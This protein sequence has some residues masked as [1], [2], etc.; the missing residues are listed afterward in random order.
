MPYRKAF[1]AVLVVHLFL[2][3]AMSAPNIVLVAIDGLND[4]AT[5][6]HGADEV[7]ADPEI[8]ARLTP[9]LDRLAELGATFTCFQATDTAAEAD[10][11]SLAP[12]AG[13]VFSLLRSA[14]YAI[15]V[16]GLSADDLETGIDEARPFDQDAAAPH[17]RER[18]PGIGESED[19][20][21]RLRWSRLIPTA[22]RRKDDLSVEAWERLTE[23]L[24]EQLA[25]AWAADKIAATEAGAPPQFVAVRF[26]GPTPPWETPGVFFD[27]FPLDKITPPPVEAD[28]LDDL[29]E[30][31]KEIGR[32]LPP[33][34]DADRC[35]AIQAYLA[36]VSYADYALG[37]VVDAV[38][39]I[40]ADDDPDNDWA[41]AFVSTRGFQLGQKGA[42][43]GGTAWEAATHTNL[44]LYAPAIT[45]PGQKIDTPVS[46][47]DV[48]PTLCA[49]AGAEPA[50]PTRG[51]NLLPLLAKRGGWPGAV[52]LTTVGADKAVSVRSFRYRLI[53]YA[54]GAE[55]LYDHD[56]DSEERYNL[57]D[58]SHA[59]L[60][61][62]FGMSQTQ[63]EAVR[64]WLGGKLQEAVARREKPGEFVPA[65]A[66]LPGDFNR[67]G[68]VD[69]ADSTVW[70]DMLGQEV[71]VGE[72]ADGDFDGRVGANDRNIWLAN[73]GRTAKDE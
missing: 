70:R 52:A 66:P 58:P 64:Q 54:D 36:C 73:Y 51:D 33:L 2:A 63:V 21:F 49:L 50:S 17:R 34:E 45:T 60:V 24:N 32:R 38:E 12:A 42:W 68:R 14:G 41:L 53:R 29:P 20:A 59:V 26:P 10:P 11:L 39:A 13:D 1:L 47:A 23:S 61:D 56:H 9:N 8:R 28:G 31:A 67:D 5:P 4:F 7:L 3:A 22:G 30:T 44:M 62:R 27:R 65:K 15:A 16:T 19:G 57:L 18:G 35:A 55:E 37:K 6:L 71:P 46:V 72:G 48:A 25:A 69:A 43:G 40:N